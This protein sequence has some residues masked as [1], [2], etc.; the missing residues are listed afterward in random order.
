MKTIIIAGLLAVAALAPA[1]RAVEQPHYNFR[2]PGGAIHCWITTQDGDADYAP[3]SFTGNARCST[4]SLIRSGRRTEV[5]VDEKGRAEVV[6]PDCQICLGGV[7]MRGGTTLRAGRTY[8]FKYPWRTGRT[9]FW[10]TVRRT[11][12]MESLH[13]R[14]PDGHGFLLRVG[15]RSCRTTLVRF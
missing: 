15:I 8:K 6:R 4:H 5:W 1:G 13:V 3:G 11:S 2:T 10:V 7:N 12:T 14:N 9:M